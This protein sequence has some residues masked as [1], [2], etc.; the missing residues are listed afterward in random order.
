M[1]APPRSAAPRT[2]SGLPHRAWH[3]ASKATLAP[4]E[5]S[6][7]YVLLL[8]APH[9]APGARTPSNDRWALVHIASVAR[10]W[11]QVRPRLLPHTFNALTVL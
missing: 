7:T 1:P 4:V 9:S 10:P 8:S 6:N 5:D 2:R 11:T 3:R